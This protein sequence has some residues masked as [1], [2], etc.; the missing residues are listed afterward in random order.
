MVDL[1]HLLKK[2]RHER[3]S[4]DFALAELVV[5]VD[6]KGVP[7]GLKKIEYDITHQLVEE[8]MLKANEW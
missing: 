8:F 6:N 4:I 5:V 2:K 7:Q 3:G 1:C